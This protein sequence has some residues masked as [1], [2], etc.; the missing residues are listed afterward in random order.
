[1]GGASGAGTVFKL[2]TGLPAAPQGLQAAPGNKQVALQWTAIAGTG[3]TYEVFEGTSP[4][5]EA[6]AP[7]K[8]GIRGTKTTI[9]ALNN[10]VPY[11]YKVAALNA[12]GLGVR[13]NE[14]GA[15]P[16]ARSGSTSE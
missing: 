6:M 8:T 4:G 15:T 16:K 11:Y 2:S 10:N 14:A 12:I 13:S 5:G 1:L 3:V 7:V 9:K